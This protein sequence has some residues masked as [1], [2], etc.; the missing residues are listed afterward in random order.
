[1]SSA[2]ILPFDVPRR[3]LAFK[4]DHSVPGTESLS[5][6]SPLLDKSVFAR[7][8]AVNPLK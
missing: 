2:K 4:L 8:V 5:G 3:S 7:V 1:M 6:L